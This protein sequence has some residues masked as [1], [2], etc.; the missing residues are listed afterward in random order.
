[1]SAKAFFWNVCGLN[2][3]DKHQPVNNWIATHQ[4]F[5]G[6]LLD[7]HIKEVQLNHVMSKVCKDWSFT[8]N[9]ASDPD[10]RIIII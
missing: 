5:F 6:A 1:M 9:H 8:S 2:D 4:V 3:P 10:G 7:T